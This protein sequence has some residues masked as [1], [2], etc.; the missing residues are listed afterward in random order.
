MKGLASGTKNNMTLQGQK[1]GVKRGKYK[2]MFL[3]GSADHGN[4][5]KVSKIYYSDGSF[6]EVVIGFADWFLKPLPGEWTVF[7]APY[8]L[9]SQMQKINGQPKLYVQQIKLD[10]SKELVGIEFPNQIT[11]HIFAITLLR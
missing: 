10:A 1:I 2:E 4:Y 3:L 9:N 7:K 5:K 11:L 8:G 6:K